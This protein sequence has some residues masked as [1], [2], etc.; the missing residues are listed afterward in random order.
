MQRDHAAAVCCAYVRNVFCAVVRMVRTTGALLF[1]RLRRHKQKSGKVSVFRRGWVT[2][3]LNF[4]WQVNF[5]ANIYGL[6]DREWPCYN[7]ATGSFHTKKLLSRPYSIEVDF[8]LKK[9]KIAFWATLSGLRVNVCTLFIARWKT[10][11]PLYIRH[12]WSFFTIPW[13][14]KQHISWPFDILAI[15]T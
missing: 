12:N 7:F 9:R 4:R 10:R 15:R 6:L 8:Y 13:D 5:S 1:F 2:L 11:G 14:R 3:R